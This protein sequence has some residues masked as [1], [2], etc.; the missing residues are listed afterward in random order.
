MAHSSLT[1]E[2]SLK[3]SCNYLFLSFT[4]SLF[5]SF[6]IEHTTLFLWAPR[7]TDWANLPVDTNVL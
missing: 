7:S 5:H 4:L 6:S 2:G 3:A 1:L